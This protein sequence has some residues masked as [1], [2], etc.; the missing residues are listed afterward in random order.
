MA[1]AQYMARIPPGFRFAPTDYELIEDYLSN[2]A[3]GQPLPCDEDIHDCEIYGDKEP[4]KLFGETTSETCYVFTKLRKKGKGRRI[5]RTAGSGTWKGQRTDPVMDSE[6]NH[7]GDRKLFVFK[8]EGGSKNDEKGHW[9]MHEFSLVNDDQVGDWVLCRIYNKNNTNRALEHCNYDSEDE[10]LGTIPA[11]ASISSQYNTEYQLSREGSS[12]GT[13]LGTQ[14]D[15]LFDATMGSDSIN[16]GLISD[17][18]GIYSDLSMVNPLK[19]TL[20]SLYCIEDETTWPLTSKKF[21]G[22]SNANDGGC[23]EIATLPS[24]LPPTAPLQQHQ[25]QLQQQQANTLHDRE[26]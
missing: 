2:K 26:V 11:S 25:Q 8:V 15:T 19:R 17:Q 1:S 14:G 24:Q 4:W 23:L 6:K 20:P 21:R 5:D 18:M 13:L 16:N 22:N 10:M 3:R 9:I 7:V 12:F